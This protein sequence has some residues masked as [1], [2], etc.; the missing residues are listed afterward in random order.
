MSPGGPPMNGMNAG[1]VHPVPD[2]RHSGFFAS[3]PRRGGSRSRS[4]YVHTWGDQQ[5]RRGTPSTPSVGS[6]DDGLFG[7][8]VV[9]P[10]P[11][12]L[13]SL[14]REREYDQEDDEDDSSS[15]ESDGDEDSDDDSV[16]FEDGSVS[17]SLNL[18]LR[19]ECKEPDLAP[20]PIEIRIGEGEAS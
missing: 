9:H 19:G 13:G 3:S 7:S 11:A 6:I 20:L 1:M 10:P 2:R 8:S 17:D 5:R 16:I 12:T 4:P 14:K 15:E 18:S